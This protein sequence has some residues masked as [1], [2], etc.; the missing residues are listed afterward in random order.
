M[1]AATTEE[2][3]GEAE[4]RARRFSGA[5]TGTAGSLAADVL[6]L[7]AMIRS[8][9]R[10][11]P[12]AKPRR[13]IGLAGPAGCGK[14]LVASMLP[15][16]RRIAF[17]DPIYRGAAVMLGI[18]EA[19]IRDRVQKEMPLPGL[20]VSPRRIL[21][22]LGTEWGRRLVSPDLWIRAAVL[23]WQQAAAEGVDVVAVPDVRFPNEAHAVRAAGGEVWLIHR[24]G[25][26]PVEAHASEY[27][28]PLRMIDR[29]ILNG[30]TVDELRTRV[31]E[32]FARVR[33]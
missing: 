21:Q 28:V 20:E 12:A 22:T 4:R 23:A 30:G 11:L 17:A 13:I 3:L 33:G 25:L 14:D 29:L 16:A 2:Y 6:R 26:A 32:T 31:L 27:G 8:A 18:P 10:P 9:P 7:V 19:A 24:P 15:G 1:N 5:M